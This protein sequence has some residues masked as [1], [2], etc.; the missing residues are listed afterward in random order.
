MS[1]S[2]VFPVGELSWSRTALP[3]NLSGRSANQAFWLR[4][5][6]SGRI[7]VSAYCHVPGSA[8]VHA[9]ATLLKALVWFWLIDETYLD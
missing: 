6:V 3:A 9:V 4:V 7:M 8:Q 2:G 5:L 1:R